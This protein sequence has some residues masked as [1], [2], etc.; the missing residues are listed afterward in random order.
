MGLERSLEVPDFGVWN[1]NEENVIIGDSYLDVAVTAEILMRQGPK[2]YL[3]V[4]KFYLGE[5]FGVAPFSNREALDLMSGKNYIQNEEDI[6]QFYMHPQDLA[7]ALKNMEMTTD[8]GVLDT[9]LF[10]LAVAALDVVGKKAGS[11]VFIVVVTVK[12]QGEEE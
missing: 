8:D 10:D 4:A 2:E 6:C 1:M 3:Q 5:G 12:L 11:D 9:P 7:F